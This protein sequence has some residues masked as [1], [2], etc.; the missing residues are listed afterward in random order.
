MYVQN[1]ILV[2][3]Q[4]PVLL[5]RLLQVKQPDIM[6]VLLKATAIARCINAASRDRW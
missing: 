3:I 5:A 1:R 2:R 4:N 6:L